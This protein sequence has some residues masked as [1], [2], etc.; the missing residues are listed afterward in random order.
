MDIFN[1]QKLFGLKKRK[2]LINREDYLVIFS[3]DFLPHIGGISL[4][5]HELAN[6]FVENGKNVLVVAPKGSYIP[7]EFDN[8]YHFLEDKGFSKKSRS[9]DNALLE[10]HRINNLLDSISANYRIHRL[11]LLHPFC[12]GVPLVDYANLNNIPI[13]VYFHGFEVKSQLL[14]GYPKNHK[15]LLEN[16]LC[17][18]LR[19]RT[20]YTIG[21]CDQICVNSNYTKEIF[22][23]FQ[24]KPDILVTGCGVG[25]NSFNKYSK[26]EIDEL[27]NIKSKRKVK[28]GYADKI[29]IVFAGR[30][31]INKNIRSL[32][33]M[34]VHNCSLEAI[35]IGIGPELEN[36]VQYAQINKIDNRVRF[37][38]NITEEEKWE[39]LE[40]ADFVALLSVEIEKT[41]N[42]EGFGITLIEGALVGA[43][44]V[45]SG[46]GGMLDIINSTTN[47]L[48]CRNGKEKEN[49]KKIVKMFRNTKNFSKVRNN[50]RL[51]VLEKYNWA[52]ISKNLIK[53]WNDNGKN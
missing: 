27:V 49:A 23:G 29:V 34:V 48:V 38:G 16:K 4:M 44:P 45:T 31:V 13:S 28:F 10:D 12:Y 24:I 1:F 32:L 19:E 41:G 30:L 39:I 35:I 43:I 33:E 18:T 36:L 11:L 46:T 37:T 17:K 26:I 22:N 8:K 14:G 7:N 47:G 6:A 15:Q 25:L 9:G 53:S 40:A 42:L 20:F 5:T 52:S 50:A 3:V 2:T 51:Q 21:K